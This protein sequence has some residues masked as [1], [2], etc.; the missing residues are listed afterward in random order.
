MMVT[1]LMSALRR[2]SL[3]LL[4]LFSTKMIWSLIALR[5]S[6]VVNTRSGLFFHSGG[7]IMLSRLRSGYLRWRSVYEFWYGL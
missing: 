6:C 2:F 7:I 5:R 3:T 4:L 1:S